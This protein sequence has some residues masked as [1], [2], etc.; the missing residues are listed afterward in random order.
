MVRIG[1]IP[2]SCIVPGAG[3]GKQWRFYRSKI[4]KWIEGQS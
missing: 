3:K 4:D 2:K 1:K